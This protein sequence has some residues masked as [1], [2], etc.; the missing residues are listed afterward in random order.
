MKS[1][2][3]TRNMAPSGVAKRSRPRHQLKPAPK[4]SAF[5]LPDAE[6]SLD[7]TA[8]PSGRPG[9][10]ARRPPRLG[11]ESYPSWPRRMNAAMAAA[12]CGE[13]SA[14]AF[15]ARVGPNREFP[16]P[17]VREGRRVLWLKDDLDKAM[18]PRGDES[19]RDIA[20]DL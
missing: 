6:T 14:R 8:N 12:Y 20:G 2:I 16:L 10:F 15:L 1:E 19:E 7:F 3:P 5:S 17:R 9:A 13:A 4:S 18:D 11:P